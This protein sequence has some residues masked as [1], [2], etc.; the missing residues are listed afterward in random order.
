MAVFCFFCLIF[1]LLGAL[2]YVS[3]ELGNNLIKKEVLKMDSRNKL[4]DSVIFIKY[5]NTVLLL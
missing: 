2:L 1:C 5:R 4:N 3:V